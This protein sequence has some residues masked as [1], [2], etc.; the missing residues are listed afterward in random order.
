MKARFP[1]L[2]AIDDLW[3]HWFGWFGLGLLRGSAAVA[4]VALMRTSPAS[5]KPPEPSNPEM[6]CY[7]P[8][9]A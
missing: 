5:E 6:A 1:I 7:G 8:P 3:F 9:D 4:Q 2:D